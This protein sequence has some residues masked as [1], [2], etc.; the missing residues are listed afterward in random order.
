MKL[1]VLESVLV[2]CFAPLVA[3]CASVQSDGCPVGERLAAG[4]DTCAPIECNGGDLQGDLCVCPTGQV[5]D[6]VT[7]RDPDDPCIGLAFNE[8]NCRMGMPLQSIHY[9]N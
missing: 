2:L 6:E 8:K 4:G 9:W 1:F 3:H 7:C 5:L